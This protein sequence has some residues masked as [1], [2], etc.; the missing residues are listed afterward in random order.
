MN[1]RRHRRIEAWKGWDGVQH[2]ELLPPGILEETIITSICHPTRRWD[3]WL[4]QGKSSP[5]PARPT[6]V[7]QFA[8]LG[9]KKGAPAAPLSSSRWTAFSGNGLKT[10]PPPNTLTFA[11]IAPN[12]AVQTGLYS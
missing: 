1:D 10:P 8:S 12:R 11:D 2:L 6:D 7:M 5:L 9:R 3:G 4:H